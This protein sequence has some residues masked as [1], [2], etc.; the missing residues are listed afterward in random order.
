MVRPPVPPTSRSLAGEVANQS[1]TAPASE[2]PRA[3]QRG[4]DQREQQAE[5]Q[6][7]R[8]GAA[9]A[10]VDELREHGGEEDQHL[11]VGDAHDD[12]LPVQPAL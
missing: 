3:V 6:H 4:G 5:H 10:D 7:L 8:G 9:R 11:G 1:R 12:A 2:P